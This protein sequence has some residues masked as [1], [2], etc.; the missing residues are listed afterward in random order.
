MPHNEY[1]LTKL[2]CKCNNRFI[3]C[4]QEREKKKKT[5][6]TDI[7]RKTSLF[8]GCVNST[9]EQYIAIA[10]VLELIPFYVDAIILLFKFYICTHEFVCVFPCEQFNYH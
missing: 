2:H 6:Y 5:Q 10:L 8:M 9:R 4:L 7:A 3:Y 1:Y